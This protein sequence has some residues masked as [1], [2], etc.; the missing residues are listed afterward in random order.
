MPEPTVENVCEM[1]ALTHLHD[2]QKLKVRAAA[3]INQ[4][5][6]AVMKTQGWRELY[7]T[8][9]LVQFVISQK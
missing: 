8:P 9:A 4:H 6:D 2:V 5:S 3:F 1:L 7:K